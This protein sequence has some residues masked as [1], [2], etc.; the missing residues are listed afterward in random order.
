MEQ[1]IRVKYIKEGPI[2]YIS[3]LNLVQV[4]TRTLRRA[5]IPVLISLG[6]NPRFRISF[7]PPLAL[8]I[9]STSEY[10]DIRLKKEMKIEELTEKLNQELPLGLK[11]ICAK[12]ILSSTDSLVKSIDQSTYIVTMKLNAQRENLKNE[13]RENIEN[14]L[15]LKEIWI[16]KKGKKGIKKL[17]IR[18]SILNL[19]IVEIDI[20][21]RKLILK[22]DIKMG[23]NGNLN[24]N[25]AIKA[26]LSRYN[27]SF[28]IVE[29]SRVDMF[30]ADEEV[31]KK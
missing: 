22:L 3:H 30:I 2:K 15:V 25:Y 27:Y 20:P 6:F 23:N 16:D 1:V 13:I 12:I 8:G 19:K 4:F 26:W 18:P 11:I 29:I 17:N 9:S 14:Y 28:D 24:P 21:K 7:G 31:M 10:F 5:N